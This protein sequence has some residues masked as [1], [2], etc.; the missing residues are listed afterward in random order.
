MR[1]TTLIATAIVGT[2]FTTGVASAQPSPWVSAPVSDQI[3][4]AKALNKD[5]TDR[6][7]QAHSPGCFS[8][9]LVK[10]NK[11]LAVVSL[12]PKANV[13][14]CGS[15]TGFGY[16]IFAQRSNRWARIGGTS[17]PP[18]AACTWTKKASAAQ[19]AQMKAT[20]LCG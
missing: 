19:K 13:V 7:G 14:A 2:V 9:L 20:G 8:V 10:K 16:Q 18:G 12:T 4:I 1:V 11:N 6:G 5:A 3:A 17:G 15:R